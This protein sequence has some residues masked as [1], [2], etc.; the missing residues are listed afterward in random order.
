MKAITIE[1]ALHKKPFRPF[2]LVQDS[3]QVVRVAHPDCLIFNGAR[4]VCIVAEGRDDLHV[5][6]L[7]HLGAITYRDQPDTKKK[8]H[9][10]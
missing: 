3:G 10:S 5:L 7:I 1:Q 9:N 4:T 2:D 6:D 8:R